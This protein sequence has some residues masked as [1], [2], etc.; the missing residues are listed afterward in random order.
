[1][2]EA[3]RF[4]RTQ[5]PGAPFGSGTVGSIFDRKGMRGQEWEATP[6]AV[7]EQTL[8]GRN[9][10]KARF[11]GPPFRRGLTFP[12]PA[13]DNLWSRGRVA[14]RRGPE[15]RQ[16]RRGPVRGTADWEEQ[17]LEGRTSWT[18]RGRRAAARRAGA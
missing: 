18:P 11:G 15:E 16:E 17:G 7:E 13:G 6:E 8:K 5:S 1:L 12:F 9:P 3:S 14:F 2:R 10:K 4:G